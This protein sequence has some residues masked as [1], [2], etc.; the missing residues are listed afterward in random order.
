[1]QKKSLKQLYMKTGLVIAGEIV[2]CD[3]G[4]GVW[5]LYA[6]S[7]INKQPAEHVEVSLSKILTHFVFSLYVN[8]LY[9]NTS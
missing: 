6:I 1:M 5:F 7:K 4:N 3:L 2:L 8:S 9:N